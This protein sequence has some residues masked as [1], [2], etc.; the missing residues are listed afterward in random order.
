MDGRNRLKFKQWFV[1]ISNTEKDLDIV[2]I[3]DKY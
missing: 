1:H 2:I 3:I